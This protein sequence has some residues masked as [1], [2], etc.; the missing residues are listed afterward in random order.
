MRI[1]FEGDVFGRLTVLRDDVER[2]GF[3]ICRCTCGNTKSVCRA[4]VRLGK[5]NSC[6]CIRKEQLAARN[7][8]NATHG[9]FGTPTYSTWSSMIARCENPH[10]ASYK[11]YGARGITVCQAWRESFEVFFAD[12]GLKPEGLTLERKDNEGNYTP[13]N[14]KWATTKEQNNNRRSS[15]SLTYNGETMT[16][17]QWAE[18]TGIPLSTLCKRLNAYGFTVEQA[19]T[20]PIRVKK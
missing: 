18:R 1:G 17:A 15:R 5:I 14:C 6:G 11:D 20:K 3:W 7:K 13:E 2:R 16:F 8:R 12:M 10:N 4:D 19:L 9:M